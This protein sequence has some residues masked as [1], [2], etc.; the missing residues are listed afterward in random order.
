MKTI[1]KKLFFEDIKFHLTSK[2]FILIFLLLILSN[3]YAAIAFSTNATYIDSFITTFHIPFYMAFLFGI[4]FANSF[5]V[6]TDFDNNTS[7]IIRY[8]NKENYIKELIKTVFSNNCVVYIINLL[9]LI[10]FMNLFNGNGFEIHPYLEYNINNILY[11]VYTIIK[12]PFLI[13]VITILNV[14][15]YKFT[16]IIVAL[17]F[18]SYIMISFFNNSINYINGLSDIKFNFANMMSVNFYP[19]FGYEISFFIL[20]VSV[21]LVFSY[22]IFML[23]NS[24]NKLSSKQNY[25]LINDFKDTVKNKKLII[26]NFAI[27]TILCV[28]SK[29]ILKIDGIKNIYYTFGSNISKENFNIIELSALIFNLLFYSIITLKLFIKDIKYNPEILFLRTNFN[30]WLSKKI[31]NVLIITAIIRILSYIIVYLI[32]LKGIAFILF[33]SFLIKDI[34][35]MISF[36][37]FIILIFSIIKVSYINIIIA[38]FLLF[39]YLKFS[40]YNMVNTNIICY[41]SIIFIIVILLSLFNKLIK[42]FKYK[43]FENI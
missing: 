40:F 4:I 7:R 21:L 17:L 29:F 24:K 43:L 9:M 28:L 32:S 39:L 22:I 19:T 15:I 37:V 31:I 12:I 34:L 25:M 41:I 6:V 3:L 13:L 23:L 33:I 36:E 8:K 42:D 35:F 14:L 27:I 18:D 2:K 5:M 16:N 20:Y 10:I 1:N 38:L 26:L 11:L 30:K